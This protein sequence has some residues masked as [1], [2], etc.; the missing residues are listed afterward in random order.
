MK[1][2]MQRGC[3]YL[4]GAGPGD[5]DL[6]TVKASRYL[7]AAD[8]VVYDRLANSGVLD[9]VPRDCELIY[10]GK[11]KHLHAMTQPAINDILINKARQGLR[12]VRLK[13]G[14]PFIF[15]R[16]GEELA[17]L[18][19]AG[20]DCE[21]VPGITAATGAAASIGLPLTHRDCAQAVTFVTAHRREGVLDVDWQL[22]TR[23]GQTVV[24]YMGFSVLDDLVTALLERNVDP[25][26]RFSVVARATRID[27]M[28]LH[29]TL[30]DIRAHPDLEHMTTPALLIMHNMPEREPAQLEIRN[31]RAD[32][33]AIERALPHTKALMH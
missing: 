23:S 15:G 19:A 9:L 27:E 22:V 16:G 2:S 12:V 6:L 21:V 10:A 24:F 28:C 30:A 26:T 7:S 18:D 5:P 33:S 17:A 29:S 13:G 32:R 4:V 14:D 25:L 11:R 20:I 3:V 1:K 8:V 31:T